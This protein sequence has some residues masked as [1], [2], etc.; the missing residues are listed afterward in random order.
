MRVRLILLTGANVGAEV[1]VEDQATLGRLA[2]CDL[3]IDDSA[4]SRHHARVF[5]EAG[6]V[7]IEDL[8]SSNGTKIGGTRINQAELH[9]G[10]VIEIGQARVRVKIEAAAPVDIAAPDFVEPR[11]PSRPPRPTGEQPKS[12]PAVRGRAES[13]EVKRGRGGALLYN[14][15]PDRRNPLTDD[16][17]QRGPLLRLLTF[18]V[19]IA[20]GIVIFYLA[21]KMA[22]R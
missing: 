19:V 15:I 11:A 14:R 17:G 6:K 21:Y 10:D 13:P 1:D 8:R 18:A 3:R 7:F 20:V 16:V 22:T 9:D 4:A 5:R 12:K 2:D